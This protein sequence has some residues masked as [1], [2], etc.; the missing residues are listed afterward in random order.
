MSNGITYKFNP[1]DAQAVAHMEEIIADYK[2]Q[3][4]D[5]EQMTLRLPVR[6]HVAAFAELNGGHE[7][8]KVSDFHN[9]LNLSFSSKA[10][11]DTVRDVP[12]PQVQHQEDVTAA[13]A[14]VAEQDE[15]RDERP[16]FGG[17]S[18]VFG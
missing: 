14:R 5:G 17:V 18:P 12:V 11:D 13:P 7:Y 9:R 10:W 1:Q 2:A 4:N 16:F 6:D 3:K 8:V 15:S